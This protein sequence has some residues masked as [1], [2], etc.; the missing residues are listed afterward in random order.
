[1]ATAMIGEDLEA[2]TDLGQMSVSLCDD[3]SL[4]DSTLMDTSMPDIAQH[5]EVKTKEICVLQFY[6]LSVCLY[7]SL[8]LFPPLSV[9]SSSLSVCFSL[10]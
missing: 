9:F 10:R 5:F 2:D 6:F 8:S 7:V 3:S 4:N 1:M